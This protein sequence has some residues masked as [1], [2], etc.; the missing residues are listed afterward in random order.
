[1]LALRPKFS[2]EHHVSFLLYLGILHGG[3]VCLWHSGPEN[4]GGKIAKRHGRVRIICSK[5]IRSERATDFR[6][7]DQPKF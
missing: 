5:V 1:M 6:G 2:Y 7:R 4:D 3:Y